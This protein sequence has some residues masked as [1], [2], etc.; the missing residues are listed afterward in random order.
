M[1]AQILTW[2]SWRSWREMPS[3]IEFW[4]ETPFSSECR[5]ASHRAPET[6]RPTQPPLSW[7]GDV[8]RHRIASNLTN[9]WPLAVGL[10]HQAARGHPVLRRIRATCTSLVDSQAGR[11]SSAGQRPLFS[12]LACQWPACCVCSLPAAGDTARVPTK[13]AGV[14]SLGPACRRRRPAFWILGNL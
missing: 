6:S 3:A 10:R 1:C 8:L 2:R 13:E 12:F 9:R 4:R 7:F 14:S 5:C 11:R